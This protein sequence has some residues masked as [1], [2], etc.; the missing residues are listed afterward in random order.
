[1]KGR[2]VAI[3]VALGVLGS[4]A[5]A[6][7][8]SITILDSSSGIAVLA[9]AF[10][11]GVDVRHS[12]PFA[13]A[14]VISETLT[15]EA[16]SV[17]GSAAASLNS[18]Y[19]DPNHMWGTGSATAAFDSTTG[20]GDM[21]GSSQFAVRFQLATQHAYDLDATF[22]TTGDRSQSPNGFVSIA[23]R[24][25]VLASLYK[26]LT[27]VFAGEWFDDAHLARSGVLAPGTYYLLL[28]SS[29][30]GWNAPPGA[31]HVNAAGS[32]GFRFNLAET[33]APVPEPASLLLFGTGLLGTIARVRRRRA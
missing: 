25:F 12:L 1:M 28:Q 17:T 14:S 2:L 15:A 29:A 21:S 6:R 5:L 16:G 30:V 13:R 20:S 33:A 32:F 10:E 9:H 22:T 19:A 11:G 27:P 4:S 7:A 26:G 18:S 24:S 8:D 3:G 31:A 23:D